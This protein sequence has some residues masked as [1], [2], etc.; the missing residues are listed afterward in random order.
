[1]Q[2]LRLA[3]E[4]HCTLE[5]A[6]ERCSSEYFA[7]W[8]A[9]QK[10]EPTGFVFETSQ[11]ANLCATVHNAP[12]KAMVLPQGAVRPKMRPPSDFVL[13]FGRRDLALKRVLDRRAQRRAVKQEAN[14][15]G[16]RGHGHS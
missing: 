14:D 12:I 15:D 9:F 3:R 2:W 11:W 6:R 7:L 1:M 16:K 8:C 4:L 13:E 10:L 5:E